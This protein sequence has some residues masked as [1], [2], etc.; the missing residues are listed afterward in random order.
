MPF[1]NARGMISGVT[2]VIKRLQYKD[3]AA[4]LKAKSQTSQMNNTKIRSVPDAEIRQNG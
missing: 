4:G 3:Y 2:V 1:V